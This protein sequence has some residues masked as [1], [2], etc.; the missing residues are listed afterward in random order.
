MVKKISSLLIFLLLL[1]L[2]TFAEAMPAAVQPQAIQIDEKINTGLET[3]LGKISSKDY[4]SAYAMMTDDFIQSTSLEDFK[5]IL[6]ETGLATFTQKTWTN[7]K[8]EVLGILAMADGDFSSPDG[9]VHHV[10][11]SIFVDAHNIK[12]RTISEAISLQNLKKRFPPRQELMASV[13]EDLRELAGGI[14]RND[15]GLIFELLSPGAKKNISITNI[16][17]LLRKFKKQKYD[18]SIASDASIIIPSNYP[19]LN[20]KGFMTVKGSYKNAKNKILFTLTYHY[21]WKWGLN[22]FSFKVKPQ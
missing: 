11:F 3:F 7:F 20:N 6:A 22:G 18:M 13:Q 9:R 10:T 2:T 17:T 15:A 12:I 4:E 5:I 16:R 21:E 1:P 14:T 8:K 19:T